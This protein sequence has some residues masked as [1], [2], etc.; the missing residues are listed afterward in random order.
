METKEMRVF[1][2]GNSWCFVLPNFI[3]LQESP[4]VFIDE[5]N[6]SMDSIWELLHGRN[7]NGFEL[8]E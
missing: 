3:N 1:Q 4:A 7:P 2:D 5:G 6:T 8:V